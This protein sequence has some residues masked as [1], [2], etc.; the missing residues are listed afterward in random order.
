MVFCPEKEKAFVK[1]NIKLFEVYNT[2]SSLKIA[3]SKNLL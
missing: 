3:L 2:L 1:L